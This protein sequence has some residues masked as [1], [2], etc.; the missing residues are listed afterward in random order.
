MCWWLQIGTNSAN[1]C[2]TEARLPAW[3]IILNNIAILR[4]A[5]HSHVSG[6]LSPVSL[7]LAPFLSPSLS[8]ITWVTS[9]TNTG[10]W[11]IRGFHKQ[12]WT[13]E[14]PGQVSYKHNAR[15]IDNVTTPHHRNNPGGLLFVSTISM[16][17]KMTLKGKC[18]QTLWTNFVS[19][20]PH[21]L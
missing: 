19:G 4:A 16:A 12:L 18:I 9:H 14:V 8:R 13:N 3:R 11:P 17:P 15:V 21:R 2:R 5:Q 7:T 20:Y 6:L 10:Y 1:V